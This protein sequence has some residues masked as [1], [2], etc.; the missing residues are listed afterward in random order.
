MALIS[1][2]VRKRFDSVGGHPNPRWSTWKLAWLWTTSRPFKPAPW[3]LY[4]EGST[5]HRY[6]AGMRDSLNVKGAIEA[7]R[8]GYRVLADGTLVSAQGKVLSS[9]YRGKEGYQAFA[10]PWGKRPGVKRRFIVVLAHT[11]AAYQK[12]GESAMH[13]GV[14]VRHLNGDPRD[15][16]LENLAIG[17]QS[18]NKMDIP[19]E[20][21]KRIAKV[22]ASHLRS[23]TEKQAQDLINN[24]ACG[25]TYKDLME[26]YCIAKGTVSYI[27]NGKTYPE[28]D[29]SK[30]VP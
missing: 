26:K 9:K 16:R 13:T 20:I 28:L 18:D 19:E 29:R 21:R 14:Q 25:M 6:H 10:L 12:Y 27:V 7:H 23:L 17:S 11:L 22:A 2:V 30:L 15:N 24:R 4:L 5:R 8:R 1:V 3:D